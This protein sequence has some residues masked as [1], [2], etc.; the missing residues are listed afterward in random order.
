M[1]DPPS[2]STDERQRLLPVLHPAIGE[3][4]STSSSHDIP[5]A[6]RGTQHV[7]EHALDFK[8]FSSLLLDSIPGVHVLS[9]ILKLKRIT[10]IPSY[11]VIYI[12]EFYPDGVNPHSR[13]PGTNGT[14]RIGLL[15]DVGLRNWLVLSI[16]YLLQG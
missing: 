2:S 4:L 9:Q 10:L 13:T 1:Q 7:G 3:I 14:F 16:C 12:T 11:P 8:L 15:N 5:E 6:E